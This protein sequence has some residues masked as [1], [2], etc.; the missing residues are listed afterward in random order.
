[1]LRGSITALITPM[2]DGAVDEKAFASFVEWQ[3]S[4]GI[5][6]LVPVGTTGESPTVSHEEHNR[7]VE[8]C[9]E[10]ANGRVPVIAGAGSNA[11]AE[12]VSLAQHAEKSGADAVLSVVPYYNKPNQEG[13]FQHFSAVARSVGIP[14]ILYS[15]PGRTIVDLSID[16]IARLREAHPN[17]VGAK[18]ATADMGRASLQRAKL[19]PD[20]IL[21]SGE[22]MTALGFNAHGGQGCISVTSNLAPR[23]CAEMQEKSL[24]GDYKGALAIQDKLV[25]LHKNL[26]LEPN[27]TAVKYAASRLGLCANELRLPLVKVSKETEQAVDFAL[28]HAGLI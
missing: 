18:D 9:V 20:F 17:I 1:M 25:H 15:V 3:I 28:A 23:L 24:A 19:G 7:V 16:T 4:E 5:H 26:F 10:V 6:G 13:L 27:P 14:I 21:L 2:R 11:T 12:S 22:D 8:I